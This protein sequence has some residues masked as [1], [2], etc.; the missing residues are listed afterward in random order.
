MRHKDRDLMVKIK[1]FVDEYALK[2]GGKPPSTRDIGGSVGLSHVGVIR[3]LREMDELG[4]IRYRDGKIT[5][6]AIDKIESP[7]PLVPAFSD[8]IPAGPEEDLSG[9]VEEFVSIPAS[10]KRGMNGQFFLLKV[11][12]ES[13]VDAGI[14]HGDIIIAKSQTDA[15]DGDIVVALVEGHGSTLKRLCLDEDGYFLWAENGQWPDHRRFFGRD[16]SIQ[17]IGV[18]V[19]KDI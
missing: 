3:Y 13:M 9:M 15:S 8:S 16:F 1:K 19:V 7:Q 6:D 10:F 14:S 5:T 4:M 17:G 18:K 12:G 2:N 11:S